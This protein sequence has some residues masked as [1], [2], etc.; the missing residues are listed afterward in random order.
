MDLLYPLQVDDGHHTDFQVG[1]IGDVH[2]LIGHGAVQPLVEKQ[3]RIP[4][5]V[6]PWCEGP[7]LLPEF[8]ALLHV[9]DIKAPLPL[10]AP[11]I[12]PK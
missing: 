6:F 12:V 2:L 5:H 9:V 4:G 1:V 3:V 7:G 10:S 11:A 8:V